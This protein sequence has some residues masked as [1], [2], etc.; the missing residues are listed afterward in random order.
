M[1][2]QPSQPVAYL[3][4]LTEAERHQLLVEWNDTSWP[5]E[6][7]D[8]WSSTKL[9]GR[10]QADDLQSKCFHQLFEEQVEHTPEAIAVVFEAQQLTYR[11]LNARA[12]YLARI[13]VESGVEAETVVGLLGERNPDFLTGILAIFKRSWKAWLLSPRNRLPTCRC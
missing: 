12:N 5:T 7:S 10:I 11:E 6:G 9:P 2:A 1:A 4:L 8:A 3:P 13:L